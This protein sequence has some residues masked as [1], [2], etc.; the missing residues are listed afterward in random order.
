M[1][2]YGIIFQGLVQ[3]VGFRYFVYRTAR[4]LGLTGSVQN[5]P[6]G[7]V[8]VEVQG[9]DPEIAEFLAKVRRGNGYSMVSHYDMKNMPVSLQEREFEIKVDYL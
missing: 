8:E 9:N 5:L 3:G 7:T 6:D 4:Q 2:R 1:V